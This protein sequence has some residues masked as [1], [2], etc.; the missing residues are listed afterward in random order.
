MG[1]GLESGMSDFVKS[2]QRRKKTGR[3]KSIDTE[4]KVESVRYE[5]R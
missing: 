5:H 2:K 4:K 3:L 1:L